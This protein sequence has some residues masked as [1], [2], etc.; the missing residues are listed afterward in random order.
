MVFVDGLDVAEYLTSEYAKATLDQ[1]PDALVRPFSE[2]KA[3][4]D[5]YSITINFSPLRKV[6]HSF[7]Q[8]AFFT[9]FAIQVLARP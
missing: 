6:L 4:T 2:I 3:M 5:P 1:D 9:L 7:K 8:A